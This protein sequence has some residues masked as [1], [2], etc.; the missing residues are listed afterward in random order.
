MVSYLNITRSFSPAHEITDYMAHAGNEWTEKM[1]EL[2]RLDLIEDEYRA[3]INAALPEGIS[4]VGDEFLID[5]DIDV[6][7]VRDTISDAIAAMGEDPLAEIVLRHDV[8]LDEEQ[9]S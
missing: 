6:E 1:T 9:Q 7:D 4:L 2:G 5:P 3:A 8:D